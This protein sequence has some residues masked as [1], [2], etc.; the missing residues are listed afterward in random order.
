MSDRLF[1]F[2]ETLDTN[3]SSF[4]QTAIAT[5]SRPFKVDNFKLFTFIECIDEDNIPFVTAPVSFPG[6]SVMLYQYRFTGKLPDFEKL[7]FELYPTENGEVLYLSH[8]SFSILSTKYRSI[9]IKSGHWP[10][11]ANEYRQLAAFSHIDI[12]PPLSQSTLRSHPPMEQILKLFRANYDIS[13]NGNLTLP[14]LYLEVVSLLK[15]FCFAPPGI[16]TSPDGSSF[17]FGAIRPAISAFHEKCFTSKLIGN[18]CLTP[19]T[20]KQLRAM[21]RF[22]KDSLSSFGYESGSDFH[23]FLS[24][25]HKFQSDN[26]L[27]EDNCNETTIQIIWK[28]L[29]SKNSD[30]ITAL[31]HVGVP[32]KIDTSSENEKIGELN[33][34]G[35]DEAGKKLAS[36]LS[37]IISSLPAPGNSVVTAQRHL[38]ST[39]RSAAE[40]FRGVNIEI[41]QLEG[42][43]ETVKQFAQN[44]N[45]KADNASKV[46]ENSLN[47][48]NGLSEM[49]QFATARIEE[50]KIEMNQE[51]KRTNTLVIIFFVLI[52]AYFIQRFHIGDVSKYGQKIGN[53]T[54]INQTI[55]N[56]TAINLTL[57]N[58]TQ[59]V[60]NTVDNITMENLTIQND[61]NEINLTDQSVNDTL[62]N[63]ASAIYISENVTETSDTLI[64][65]SNEKIGEKN[66]NETDII[67]VITNKEEN[68]TENNN[69]NETESNIENESENNYQND[70]TEN[71]NENEIENNNENETRN[72]FENEIENNIEN[73]TENNIEYEYKD[74]N[75]DENMDLNDIKNENQ[76]DLKEAQTGKVDDVEIEIESENQHENPVNYQHEE[77]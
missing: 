36:G 14:I 41:H 10:D 19:A 70:Y 48:I 42:R 29:L 44:I 4:L 51:L 59:N 2:P 57:E 31:A 12:I 22:V 74:A 61:T 21:L 37:K 65:K 75:N 23:S 47:V 60:N 28:V 55:L 30:P 54:L 11:V 52:L 50:A 46:A 9:S 69:E 43:I 26:G 32:I 13:E 53:M 35:C 18:C 5:I 45:E 38:L 20:V 27:P 24:A 7:G 62:D 64:H 67:D 58:L 63:I 39:A 68:T 66:E 72:N 73:D 15:A 3:P 17:Y 56:T 71:D 34:N 8:K 1:L 49:N 6:K 77:I 76:N 25:L 40:Q 33:S 16:Y